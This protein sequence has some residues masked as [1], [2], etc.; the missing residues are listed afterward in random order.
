M[1]TQKE[2]NRLAFEEAEYQ[3]RFRKNL[4]ELKWLYMELYQND[5]MFDELC[6]QMHR[7]YLERR[8]SLKEMDRRREKIRNGLNRTT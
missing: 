7:F 3:K 1:Q 8:E 2:K 5:W 6:G 4:D